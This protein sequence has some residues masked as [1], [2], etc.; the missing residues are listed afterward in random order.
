MRKSKKLTRLNNAE[1]P[2]QAL[3][4]IDPDA[5]VDDADADSDVDSTGGASDNIAA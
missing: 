3:A 4:K 2:S 1:L 5:P